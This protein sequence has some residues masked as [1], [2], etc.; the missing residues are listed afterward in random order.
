[1]TMSLMDDP[2]AYERLDPGGTRTLIRDLPRQCRAAWQE[3]QALDLPHDYGRVDKVVILGMGGLVIA[4]DLMRS[5]AALE[6]AV[7]IFVHRDYGLPRLVDDRTLLIA[8]SYSGATEET[9]SAFEIGLETGARKLVITTGGRL[10]ALAQ[11]GG[12]PAFVFDYTSTVRAA[13]GYGLMP[14]LA[15]AGK[16]GIVQDK[17][18]DVEEAALVTEEMTGRIGEHVPLARNPAKQLAERLEGRLPVIYGSGILAEVAHRWKTQLNENSKV[19]ALWE[20]LPEANHNAIVGYG[21]P[22]EM[23]ARAFVVL[24]R[25][26]A[27]SPR[28]RLR[29]DFTRQALTEAGVASEIVDAEGMSPLAQM[30]SAVL[31]GDYVSL[32]LAILAGVDP[33]PT[34]V[35]AD[36]KRWL[37]DRQT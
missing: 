33:S 18:A 28:I 6:S 8:M 30:M 29:Y 37:A 13:L 27:L 19:W 36:L 26:P 17:A 21:L 25:A 2:H 3:A 5:L 32:Y 12:V 15:V 11:A 31:F 20:E 7:P 35:I 23:A 24:L 34:T 10:L 4:G 14:L 16:A 22:Q 9:V 1:V